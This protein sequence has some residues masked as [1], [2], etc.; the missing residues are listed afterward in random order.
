MYFH[1]LGDINFEKL[2]TQTYK[3]NLKIFN[4][5]QQI[6]FFYDWKDTPDYM[7]LEISPFQIRFRLVTVSAQK[8]WPLWFSVLVLDLNQIV[9]SVVH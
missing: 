1:F 2:K 4:V 8:Y 3:N 5:W 6:C 7:S 9:V